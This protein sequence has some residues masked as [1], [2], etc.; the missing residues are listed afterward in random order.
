MA[1]NLEKAV[2]SK[3]R[4][5]STEKQEDVLQFLELIQPDLSEKFTITEVEQAK[6]IRDR[7]KKRALA[8]SR[9]S[10]SELWDEFN[11][12]KGA[13]SEEYDGKAD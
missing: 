8:N 11:E 9:K 3:F 1:A 6:E 5:L 4:N 7:A 2:I 12:I 13:I 10:S